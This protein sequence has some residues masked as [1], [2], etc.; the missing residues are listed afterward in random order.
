MKKKPETCVSIEEIRDAI[1]SIDNEIIQL[2][3][4]RYKYVK[5]IVKFKHDEEG[6]IAEERRD[7]VIEQR[8]LWAKEYGLDHQ[9]FEAIYKT[10]INS[11]IK[12]ELEILK[13][14]NLVS[15]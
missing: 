8:A 14:R 11:N 13:S 15:K 12:K 4:E 10:L 9:V 3:A 2:F 6:I 7:A 1:D 5:E